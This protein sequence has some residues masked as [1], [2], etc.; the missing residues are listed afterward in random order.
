MEFRVLRPDSTAA[1]IDGIGRCERDAEGGATRLSGINLDVTARKQAEAALREVRDQ[2]REHAETMRRLLEGASQG[3]LSI[4][5][6]GTIVTANA[7]VEAMFAW[8]PGSL[9]GQAIDVLLPTAVRE[10][11][12]RHQAEYFAGPR[13]RPMGEGRA[14]LGQRR[15]GSVFPVEIPSTTSRPRLATGPSP[16]SPTSP[17]GSGPAS[18]SGTASGASAWPW[19]R[20]RQ[21]PGAGTSTRTW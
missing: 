13:S 7:A 10:R 14:L 9:E 19:T 2:R 11:H 21:G 20:R 8:A 17:N 12:Q 6:A 3:I 16:S 18:T 4:D 1:W 5:T 15:D